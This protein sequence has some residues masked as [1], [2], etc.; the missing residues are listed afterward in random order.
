MLCP[1]MRAQE[2][3]QD[4]AENGLNKRYKIA[5]NEFTSTVHEKQASTADAVIA[6][7]DALVNNGDRTTSASH[8]ERIGEAYQAVKRGLKK[9]R[10][11]DVVEQ[12]EAQYLMD[13]NVHTLYCTTER[14]VTE[15][16]DKDGN[17]K[18]RTSYDYN[19]KV[20]VTL[21]SHNLKTNKKFSHDFTGHGSSISSSEDAIGYALMDLRNE[22]ARRYNM[23][24]PV[25]GHIV[26]VAATNKA[27]KWKRVI[28]DVGSAE[29]IYTDQELNFIV[30]LYET[31]ATTILHAR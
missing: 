17:K 20:I 31:P 19:A 7:V 15:I 25:M 10:R 29:R 4:E 6:V 16:K 3:T 2:A 26:E 21:T 12:E 13:C 30:K 28:V 27:G 8:T 22:I 14:K 24:Y 5:F 1:G 18:K 23:S 9:I 11:F